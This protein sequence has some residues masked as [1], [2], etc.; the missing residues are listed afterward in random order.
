MICTDVAEER[1]WQEW[2]RLYDVAVTQAAAGK[3]LVV[4]GEETAEEVGL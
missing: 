1:W 3:W 4:A 2:Q